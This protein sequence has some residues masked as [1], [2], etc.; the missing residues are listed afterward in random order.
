MRK[1]LSNTLKLI[2]EQGPQV[3][4]NGSI[5][6]SLVAYIQSRGG[7]M[8]EADIANYTVSIEDPIT[9]WYH[10]REVITC[11]APCSG[12]ALIQALNILEGF[13]LGKQGHM[14]A[15]GVHLLVEAMKCIFR[16]LSS[17]YRCC[18]CSN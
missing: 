17:N 6:K 1:N 10:G 15:E 4:Y 13:S 9:G 7:I 14:T 18:G 2:S 3:F 16:V 12:P 11:G 8:T 5:S